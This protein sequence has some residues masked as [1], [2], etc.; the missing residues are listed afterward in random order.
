MT[1]TKGQLLAQ[2]TKVRSLIDDAVKEVVTA[3]AQIEGVRPAD[4]A[5][6]A[7]AK[8]MMDNIGLVRGRPLHYPYVGSGIGR[9]A[10]VELEDGSVKL[11]LINGIGI[12]IM[13]H[14]HPKVMA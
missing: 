2:S 14:S 8:E 12:H 13:G 9:G 6:A 10:Y 1:T 3:S 11:D 5:K 4:P 7:K